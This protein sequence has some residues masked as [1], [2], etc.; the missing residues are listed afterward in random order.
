MLFVCRAEKYL[1]IIVHS[2]LTKTHYDATCFVFQRTLQDKYSLFKVKMKKNAMQKSTVHIITYTQGIL[3]NI[4]Y[5]F[6]DLM[7]L[8]IWVN[9]IQ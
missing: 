1:P 3:I 8:Y 9:K 5:S 6:K 2:I 4:H 7:K